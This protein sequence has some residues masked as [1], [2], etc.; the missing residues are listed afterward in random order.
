M[1]D[2]YDQATVAALLGV[3]KSTVSNWVRARREISPPY[4]ARVLE[5]HDVLARVHQ[6]F[7]P[8]LAARWLTGREP[9]LGGARPI[10][11]LGS[12]GAA[13]VIDAL[14]AISAG[15]YA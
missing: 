14:E 3:D 2:A 1:I 5:V 4:R 10:D 12:R 11:V 8:K 7:N 13:P 15:G 6:V 9:L